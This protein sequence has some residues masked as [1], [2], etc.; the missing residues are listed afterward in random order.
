MSQKLLSGTLGVSH[1]IKDCQTFK[2][3][4]KNFAPQKMS[5]FRINAPL[6][7]M[8]LE[9]MEFQ[10][11]ALIVPA[12]VCENVNPFYQCHWFYGKP[13]DI[14]RLYKYFSSKRNCSN[15]I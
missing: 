5:H 8:E 4:P 15:L 7:E 3:F 13:D 14:V 11:Y 1:K 2:N 6:R 10:R 9:K 12:I